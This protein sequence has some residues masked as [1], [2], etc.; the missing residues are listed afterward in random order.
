MPDDR[1]RRGPDRRTTARRE[2]DRTLHYARERLLA[3]ALVVADKYANP[4]SV[5]LTYGV[6]LGAELQHLAE[7]AADYKRAETDAFATE[8]QD[9][10]G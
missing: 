2:A 7:V 4:A 9:A 10:G 1:P 3:A 5:G 8:P 6:A